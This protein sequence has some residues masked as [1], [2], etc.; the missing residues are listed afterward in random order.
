MYG[1]ENSAE[2]GFDVERTILLLGNPE[3]YEVSREVKI[4]ELHQMEQVRE[5]LKDTLL[6]FRARYGVGRAIAAPQIGV[7]KRVIYRH[8]DT[9]VLFI[10]PR[11][12]FPEQE[13]IDVLD[14]CMS[15]PDLLV[16]VKRYKRCIIYYKDLE[17]ND[18]SMEL[19]GDMSEL[20]QHE[21]DHLDGILA[22]LRAVDETPLTDDVRRL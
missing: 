16:R 13:M 10:N 15:F 21:Y 9:P 1:N 14:D 7:K 6:A 22:T 8:L 17:W 12:A 11:L 19:E 2:G 20:I 3:L 4:E 5:D 18:C